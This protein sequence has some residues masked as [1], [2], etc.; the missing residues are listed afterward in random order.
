[1]GATF[2]WRVRWFESVDT[3]TRQSAGTI[4]ATHLIG[5]AIGA[6]L[7]AI[8]LIPFAGLSRTTVSTRLLSCCWASLSEW[9]TREAGC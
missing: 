9:P 2:A 7:A 5:G 6:A 4:Y 3:S 8:L 1:M